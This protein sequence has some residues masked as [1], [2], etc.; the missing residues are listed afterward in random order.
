MTKQ[1]Y[2]IFVAYPCFVSFISLYNYK[3]YHT[4][5]LL[6]LFNIINFTI[7]LDLISL[8]LKKQGSERIFFPNPVIFAGLVVFRLSTLDLCAAKSR[9]KLFAEH[10]RE[11]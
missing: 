1:G 4:Y 2:A 9:N 11:S 3:Y 5:I 8:Q 10:L 7:Y 6:N